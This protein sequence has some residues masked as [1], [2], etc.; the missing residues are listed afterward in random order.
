[1]SMIDMALIFEM[2]MYAF[3]Y[4]WL[5]FILIFIMHFLMPQNILETYFKE[6]YFKLSE[7]A[8]FSGFPFGYIRTVMFMRVLGFPTSG[9]KRGV[10]KAHEIAPAWFCKS[11]K[12]IIMSFC[13]SFVLFLL[14]IG[15]SGLHMMLYE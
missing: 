10:E 11:S 8:A 6:P 3:I 9:K 13:I 2:L 1:M 7:I 15:V 14:I 12:Y 4:V 5:N